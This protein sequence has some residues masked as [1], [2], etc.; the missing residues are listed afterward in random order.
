VSRKAMNIGLASATIEQLYNAQLISTSADLYSLQYND[1]IKLERFAEKSVLNLLQSIEESKN[2]PFH[3]VLYAIGIRYVGETVAKTLA[4]AFGSIDKIQEASL[5]QLE[6]VDEIGTKIAESIK[7]YFKNT[8][9]IEFIEK[10]KQNELQFS[11]QMEQNISDVELPLQNMSIIIS[12]VFA[13]HSRDEM[14]DLIEKY[15]GKNV[16][17]I[18][19][20]TSFMLAGEGVGPS[21]LEKAE[22]NNVKIINE[23]EFYTMIGLNV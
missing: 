14:K 11:R 6:S 7:Q 22:K 16:S 15:G 1:L 8:E 5:L 2:T 23:D 19:K 10:L 20:N 12:G 17:S 9:N 13:K 21:K 3:R 18:S 4:K